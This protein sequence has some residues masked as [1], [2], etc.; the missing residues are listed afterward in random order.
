MRNRL[1]LT[2]I[3]LFIFVVA[4]RAQTTAFTYQ[5]KLSDNGSPAAGQYDFQFKLFDTAAVGTGTQQGTTQTLTNVTVA[6]GVFTAQ[7]DFGAC[8]S[9]FNGAARFLEIAVKPSGGGSYTTLTP[10]QPITATPY[11]MKTINLTFN[12]PYNDELGTVFTASNTFA[13]ESAGVNTTPDPDPLVFLGKLNAFFG[14]GAGRANTTGFRNAFFGFEAGQANTIGFNN[15]FFGF[16]AGQANTEGIRNAFFGSGAG[17]ANIFGVANAYFGNEAGYNNEGSENTF[18]GGRAGL[19][20]TEVSQ[21]TFIGS[22]ADFNVPNPTGIRN[23]LLGYS[24]TINSGVSNGTAI[25]AL[26]TVTQSDSLVLGGIT[27]VNGG[28]SVK[29]GIGTTAPAYKMHVI[30]S[31][32]T[33]LR[34]QTNL[35]GGTL[36]S[37]GG[38]GDFQIDASGTPGGRFVV[39]ESGNVGIGT[40]VPSDKLEVNGLLR[41]NGLGSSGGTQLCRNGS[42]QIAAC[43]SSLRYKTNVA[44]LPSGMSLIN[45][46]RPVTFDWKQGG[47]HDLGL[48]AE[49]VAKVEPLL[50]THNE[51][52]EI[53]GVKYDRIAVV[54]I[55]AIKQQQEQMER[56]KAENDKLKQQLR[57]QEERLLRLEAAMSKVTGKN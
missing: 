22:S 40:T 39:K 55:N 28:T 9:C 20:T 2:S 57:Q 24:T 5:G 43:S 35:T 38:N 18:I 50:V 26:A 52:G 31:S 1:L 19:F 45:R 21:N 49:E 15:A 48:V 12:A 6:A 42:N 13:G 36:A 11:A 46:L 27:G 7:L 10:R 37:F 25:G 34:V 16:E 17:Q 4:A 29:V 47:E 3:C 41:L 33:G 30:D 23:T 14:A 51:R 44:T 54:L 53:E 8:D 56:Q 32:N